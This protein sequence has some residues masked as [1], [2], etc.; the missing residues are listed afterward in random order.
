MNH[1]IEW[2]EFVSHTYATVVAESDPE[3]GTTTKEAYSEAGT[4][5][6]AAVKAGEVE[7][8]LRQVIRQ[9]LERAD[10]SHGRRADKLIA[11]T[12]AGVL[13]MLDTEDQLNT[14]VTLGGG[15]R[16]CWRHVNED[17]LVAMDQ[18]RYKNLANAQNAYHEWRKSFDIARPIL[19]RHGMIET[20][21]QAGA[22][23]PVEVGAA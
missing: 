1:P 15:R 8:D 20:A 16:K 18:E 22:F 12:V 19:R 14:V 2:D 4:R 5:L 23:A 3:S 11:D 13:Y 7:V 6:E 9:S 17:D 10:K 21:H